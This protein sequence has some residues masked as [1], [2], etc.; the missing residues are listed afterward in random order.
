MQRFI[1]VIITIFCFGVIY[2]DCFSQ[3][4]QA[5]TPE[6]RAYLQKQQRKN[7]KKRQ[8]KSIQRENLSID[9]KT[10]KSEKIVAASNPKLERDAATGFKRAAKPSVTKTLEN[11]A[12]QSQEQ[13]NFDSLNQKLRYLKTRANPTQEQLT[14]IKTIEDQIQKMIPV[15]EELDC[16]K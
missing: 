12:S 14:L 11:R 3:S 6:E 4:K 10:H 15:L 8:Y 1:I 16:K 13:K 2:T 9:T 7:L 5:L